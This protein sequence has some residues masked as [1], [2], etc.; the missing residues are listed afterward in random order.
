MPRFT[1]T[2][3][4]TL[5]ALL[6]CAASPFVSAAPDANDEA[7]AALCSGERLAFEAPPLARFDGNGDH[8]ISERE[9]ARCE[10]LA[11]VFERLD[12]DG[13]GV[14]SPVEYATFPDVWRRR[15]RAFTDPD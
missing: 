2:C 6:L 12:L 4:G 1:L 10:S 7:L 13:N 9:T 15:Q 11:V 8:A 3:S 14:L 5:P